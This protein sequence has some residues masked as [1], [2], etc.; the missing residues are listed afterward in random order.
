MANPVFVAI[1]ANVWTLVAA[2]V[3]TGNI[4]IKDTSPTYLQ[5]YREAS[6]PAPVQRDDGVTFSENA[7]ISASSPIDVYIYAIDKI[8]RVRVDV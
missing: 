8:G 1:P 4:Y 3:T 6:D 5:T 7:T 2:G